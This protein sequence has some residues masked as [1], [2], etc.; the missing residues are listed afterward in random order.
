MKQYKES[1][2]YLFFILFHCEG[3]Q[4]SRL[5][6]SWGL[7]DPPKTLLWWGPQLLISKLT[8]PWPPQTLYAYCLQTSPKRCCGEHRSNYFQNYHSHGQHSTGR[9][10]CGYKTLRWTYFRWCWVQRTP[11]VWTELLVNQWTRF[12]LFSVC[13]FLPPVVKI[14]RRSKSI[15]ADFFC[16]HHRITMRPVSMLGRL[17]PVSEILQMGLCPVFFN[18]FTN[19]R[20]SLGPRELNNIEAGPIMMRY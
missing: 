17:G 15:A 19:P 3:M 6:P 7:P 2:I 20:C 10:N 16:C 11:F 5:S 4:F 1:I 12:V 13:V 9:N 8:L 14:N 18:L